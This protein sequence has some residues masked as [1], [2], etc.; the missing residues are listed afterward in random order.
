MLWMAYFLGML[1]TQVAAYVFLALVWTTR[2]QRNIASMF[3]FKTGYFVFNP[4]F[5]P[6]ALTVSG[7]RYRVAAIC[8]FGAMIVVGALGPTVMS[9][10]LTTHPS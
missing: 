8:C 2:K 10:S 6:G 5:R 3:F 4:L 9:H 1:T 7:R